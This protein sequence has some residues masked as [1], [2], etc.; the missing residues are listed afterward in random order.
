MDGTGDGDGVTAFKDIIVVE[1]KVI[2][3]FGLHNIIVITI[4]LTLLHTSVE[5]CCRL[6]SHNFWTTLQGVTAHQTSCL[7][8]PGFPRLIKVVQQFTGNRSRR[9]SS[10]NESFGI[11]DIPSSFAL[12]SFRLCV[13][14]PRIGLNC[15]LN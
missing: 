12:R 1:G 5:N 3:A 2:Y 9:V 11:L 14:T 13:N 6:S 10:Y 4:T 8:F 7:Q 15:R